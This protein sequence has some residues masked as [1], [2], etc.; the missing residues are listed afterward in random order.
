[1]NTKIV[2]TI[3]SD[4]SDYY[5]EQVI[6]SVYS[7]RLYNQCAN[8]FLIVDAPT[9]ES[10]V[11]NR[12]RIRRMVDEIIVIDVPNEYNKMRR[13]RFLKTNVRRFVQGDYL[14]VDSDTVVCD[15]LSAIDKC[16]Y[17]MA[18]V[19]DENGTLE[20]TDQKLIEKCDKAG[21]H[22]MAGKPYYNSGIMFVKDN[23]ACYNFYELWNQLWLTSLQ[24]GVPNDQPAL[25]YANVKTHY[26]IGELQG[27]WNCQIKKSEGMKLLNEALIIHYYYGAGN[28]NAVL[29][30]LIFDRVKQKG[31][32]DVYI[33]NII[34]APKTIFYATFSLPEDMFY[35]YVTADLIHI[36]FESRT[37]YKLM[38][39]I[40]RLLFKPI[41]YFNK[42]KTKICRR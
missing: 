9:Q 20:A 4:A 3:I 32:V 42:I 18:L 14:F 19:A 29:Q 7:V 28:P 8:I 40:G 41:K 25:N 31:I 26:I 34:H 24:N 27:K 17:L 39:K 15:D 13:S 21:F 36:F 1:M 22:E 11:G 12:S 5:L 6:I 16:E 10:L 30:N 38:G 37:L 23:V 35:E 33:A 2:Y